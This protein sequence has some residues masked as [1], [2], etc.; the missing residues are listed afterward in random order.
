MA[1]KRK[2]ASSKTAPETAAP[3]APGLR[4]SPEADERNGGQPEGFRP[5]VA[6]LRPPYSVG[7]SG[8]ASDV[9]RV[10]FRYGLGTRELP[11]DPDGTERLIQLLKR[12]H[13][14]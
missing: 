2:R 12:Q 8:R 1:T 14:G 13:G 9:T 11:P 7:G 3:A 10:E 6:S 4:G 5:E